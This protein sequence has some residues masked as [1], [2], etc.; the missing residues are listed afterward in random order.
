[1]IEQQSRPSW[2]ANFNTSCP[3]EL[4]LDIETIATFA[5]CE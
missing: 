1:M 5:G 4:D 3:L 2:R